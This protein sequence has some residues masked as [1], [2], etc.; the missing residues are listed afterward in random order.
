MPKRLTTEEVIKRFRQVHS[1]RYGYDKVIYTGF[2]KK[3]CI[4]CY[5]HGVFWQN[6]YNHLKGQNCPICSHRNYKYTTGEW[7][8][9]AKEVH[10]ENKYD[11]SKF[12]YI[13]SRIKGCI[14]CI[15]HGEFWQTSDNHLLGRGCPKCGND[16]KKNNHT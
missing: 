15:E 10:G 1:D 5:K 14:I 4:T 7:K 2:N 13:N 3:V 6:I 16:K 11:Y 8:V 9:K 12:E